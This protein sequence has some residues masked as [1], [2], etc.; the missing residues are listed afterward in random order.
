LELHARIFDRRAIGGHRRSEG[1]CT[2]T[3]LVNLFAG[4]KASVGEVLRPL[5]GDLGLV[6]LCGV[7]REVRF[8]LMERRFEGTTI[9][10]E[11][12]LSGLYVVALLKIDGG[13]LAGDLRAN[14]DGGIR[15]RRADQMDL[16][17]HILLN[18]RRDGHGH[19]WRR[20]CVPLRLL[21]RAPKTRWKSEGR[22]RGDDQTTCNTHC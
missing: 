22:Q 4:D 6:R 13:E 20:R 8:R 3:R 16:E 19:G 21:S 9:Q 5:R 17:G 18:D 15:L 14:G 2:R 1:G 7:A 10:R 12:D 11:E